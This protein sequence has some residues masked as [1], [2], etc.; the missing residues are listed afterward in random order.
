MRKQAWNGAPPVDGDE[1]RA[2]L[3]AAAIESIDR[4]GVER[5]TVGTIAETAGVT[6]ATVY[7]HF[8]DGQDLINEAIIQASGGLLE[9]LFK[10]LDRFAAPETRLVEAMVYL[11]NTLPNEPLL[12]HI[13]ATADR[14]MVVKSF[15]PVAN[16]YAA[17]ALARILG[18]SDSDPDSRDRLGAS[19]ELL[20]RLLFTLVLADGT[21]AETDARLRDNLRRLIVPV[22]ACAEAV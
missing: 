13:F 12:S 8:A 20:I 6:R 3:L 22:V 4:Q 10:Y 7:N 11:K 16:R 18:V 15:G 19:A 14:R 1:A 9:R 5:T 17:I 2:R 21:F